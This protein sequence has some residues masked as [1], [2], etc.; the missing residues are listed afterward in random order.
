[1]PLEVEMKK[2]KSRHLYFLSLSYALFPSAMIS[3]AVVISG[4]LFFLEENIY[5]WC[6]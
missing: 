4:F 1:M 2:Q 5:I 3:N 6:D